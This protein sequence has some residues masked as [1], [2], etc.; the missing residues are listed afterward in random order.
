[1]SKQNKM[2]GVQL[3]WELMGNSG[4]PLVLVHGSWVDH[5]NWDAV[6]PFLSRSFRV[7]T[8]DRRG[9]SQSE[10]PASPGSVREDVADFAAL[11]EELRLAP[12]HIVGHSFGGS[13][14]LRLAGERPDLFRSL[15]VH[16]P[17]LM[18][19]LADDSNGQVALQAIK[20]RI[21]AVVELLEAGDMEGGAR[22]FVETIAFGPGAWAQLPS[23]LQKIVIFNAPTF[24]DEMRD[25]EALSIDLARLRSFFHPAL[26]TLGEQGPPF[27]TPIVEKVANVLPQAER[28]I[29]AAAGH[30]PE[31]SH[32]EVYV[33]A[34]VEF[35]TRVTGSPHH[36]S[37]TQI[38]VSG[39]DGGRPRQ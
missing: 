24:L 34:V 16:E 30:E 31:Q 20:E 13:I 22:Q 26:L 18:S 28:K 3:F 27:F 12:A 11:I 19:L 4:E 7:L 23:D 2:N 8:Y 38:D 33:A 32:P 17:P 1:M 35:I 36:L 5:H 21:A 39:E 6:V 14:V 15:I 37:T 25:P 29:F 10:R 9:H